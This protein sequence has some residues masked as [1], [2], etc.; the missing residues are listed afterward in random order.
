MHNRGPEGDDRESESKMFE[1]IMAENFP[2]LKKKTDIK[3]QEAQRV[4]KKMNPDSTTPRHVI[5]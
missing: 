4:S 5:I 3:E 1:E 2:N